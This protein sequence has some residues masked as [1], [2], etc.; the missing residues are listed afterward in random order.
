MRHSYPLGS[1]NLYQASREKPA[2]WKLNTTIVSQ[3][4]SSLRDG[5]APMG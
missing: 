5:S 1:A 2:P 4:D 3:H